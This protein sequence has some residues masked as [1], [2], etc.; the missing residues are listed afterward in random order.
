MMHE[1]PIPPRRHLPSLPPEVEGVILKCL[2]KDP[3]KRYPTAKALASDIGA[4][5]RGEPVTARP[6]T[7][8][9]RLWLKIRRN[10][11]LTLSR[12]AL[13]LALLLPQVRA[14]LPGGEPVMVAVADFDNQT[15]DE[16]LDGLSGMLITSLEQSRKLSVLTRSRMFDLARQQGHPNA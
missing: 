7:R 3:Q 14:L 12:P 15:G 9:D 10:N 4:A 2:E 1:D 11:P 6:P 5:L 13:V 16:G 8:V